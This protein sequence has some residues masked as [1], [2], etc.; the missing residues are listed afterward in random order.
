ME[1]DVEG[2]KEA[3]TTNGSS[4][5]CKH[6]LDIA[7]SKNITFRMTDMQLQP[8]YV[9][10]DGAFSPGTVLFAWSALSV[11]NSGDFKCFSRK[12]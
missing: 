12:L 2:L 10:K 4:Y 8:Y 6:G 1:G 7:L 11:I 9:K 5:L 3:K